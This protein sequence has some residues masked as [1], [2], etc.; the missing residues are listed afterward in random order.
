MV[1]CAFSISPSCITRGFVINS[2]VA[3]AD[4]ALVL[5]KLNT[6]ELASVNVT[7]IESALPESSDTK[8]LFM[9]ALELLGAV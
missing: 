7:D 3:F 1:A 9:I 4:T 2:S 8:I 5:N 6:L